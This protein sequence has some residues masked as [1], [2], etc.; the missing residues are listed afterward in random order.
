MFYYNCSIYIFILVMQWLVFRI[1]V[2][3]LHIL[4]LK[5]VVFTVNDPNF[6]YLGFEKVSFF[7]VIVPLGLV[8]VN[9]CTN[10]SNIFLH[11]GV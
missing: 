9:F 2:P 5:R 11:K 10:C 4:V 7:T 6:S 1:L 3:N 8:K